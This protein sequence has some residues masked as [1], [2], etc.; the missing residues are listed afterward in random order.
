MSI[1]IQLGGG[2]EVGVEHYGVN[3]FTRSDD[4]KYCSNCIIVCISLNNDWG[5]RNPVWEY[6]SRSE[7]IP[8]IDECF[9]DFL[10]ELEGN[11][12]ASKTSE[13]NDHFGVVIDELSI[14]VCKPKERLN[15][16]DSS[17][18]GPILD[19]LRHILLIGVVFKEEASNFW[20]YEDL[21]ETLDQCSQYQ[22]S[23]DWESVLISMKVLG[24]LTQVISSLIQAG[25]PL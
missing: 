24:F 19:D 16:L 7:S 14:E 25:S 8:K 15:V 6:R 2:Q 13:G 18:F 20:W 1:I 9:T 17:G 4:R 10:E 12:F 5:L 21:W 22:A 23:M 3:F 11:V